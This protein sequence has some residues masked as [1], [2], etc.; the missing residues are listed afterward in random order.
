M[1][2]SLGRSAKVTSVEG[3]SG[4]LAASPTSGIGRSIGSVVPVGGVSGRGVDLCED[5][6]LWDAVWCWE[7]VCGSE[8]EKDEV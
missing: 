1:G 8:H 7:D 4:D 6:G 3:M 5:G 2:C